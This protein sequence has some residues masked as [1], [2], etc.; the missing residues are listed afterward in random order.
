MIWKKGSRPAIIGGLI[1]NQYR[2]KINAILMFYS[3]WAP[4]KLE[5]H[6]KMDHWEQPVKPATSN[7]KPSESDEWGDEENDEEKANDD[8]VEEGSDGWGAG[9][10]KNSTTTD[11]EDPF[12]DNFMAAGFLTA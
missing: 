6:D 8:A 2:S 1:E 7:K 10:D 4:E 3:R 9:K 12:Y 11:H 5:E